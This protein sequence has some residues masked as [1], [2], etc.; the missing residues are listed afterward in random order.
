MM[1]KGQEALPRDVEKLRQ[2]LAADW[3]HF[4]STGL[5]LDGDEVDAWMAAIERGQNPDLPEL[6][7]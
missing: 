2:E 1:V 4:Q 6:H 5:H 3:E 7:V